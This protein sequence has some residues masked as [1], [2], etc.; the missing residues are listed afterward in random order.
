MKRFIKICYML[1]LQVLLLYSNLI[2]GDC[3]TSSTQFFELQSLCG[4]NSYCVAGSFITNGDEPVISQTEPFCVRRIANGYYAVTLKQ[5]FCCPISAVAMADIENPSGCFPVSSTDYPVNQSESIKLAVSPDR[6][7]LAVS[8][9]DSDNISVFSINSDCTLRPTSSP[10]SFPVDAF[11]VGLAFSPNCL[12]VTNAG[13]T[14]GLLSVFSRNGSNCGLNLPAKTVDSGGIAPFGVSFSPDG[15]CFAVANLSSTE[16]PASPNVTIFSVKNGCELI[17]GAQIPVQP[18]FVSGALFG[19]VV[20]FLSN[21]CLAILNGNN[22]ELYSI[23]DDCE[24]SLTDSAPIQNPISIAFS[25]INNCLVVTSFPNST[26]PP[27]Q[28]GIN[29]FE[30]ISNNTGKCSLQLVNQII[31]D[32]DKTPIIPTSLDFSP[33]GSC[34]A[35]NS[36]NAVTDTNSVSIFKVDPATCGLTFTSSFDG[37]PQGNPSSDLRFLS[38]NC[39]ASVNTSTNNVTVVDVVPSAGQIVPSMVCQAMTPGCFIVQLDLPAGQSD[40]GIRVSFFATQCT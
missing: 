4:S 11:P 20:N 1:V 29:I 23:S 15:K 31:N 9:V 38:E 32:T 6:K 12:V 39:F 24:P 10:P 17:P 30:V 16:T 28:N 19:Q 14:A 27:F 7:C 21:S 22:I 18:F 40:A 33:D 2:N 36:Y 13:A 26:P 3:A 5:P 37:L 8:N 34:L 25:P 35:I